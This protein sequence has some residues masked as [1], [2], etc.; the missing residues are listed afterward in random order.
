V[1]CSGIPTPVSRLIQPKRRFV[2]RGH[3]YREKPWEEF[4][5]I[6]DDLMTSY[7]APGDGEE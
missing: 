1:S 6:V 4:H 2:V 5:K 3:A 7:S